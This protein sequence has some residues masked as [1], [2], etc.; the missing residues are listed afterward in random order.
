MP[1]KLGIRSSLYEKSVLYLLEM[2]NVD[3]LHTIYPLSRDPLWSFYWPSSPLLVHVI[4]ECPLRLIKSIIPD[5]SLR[6]CNV[7]CDI[8]KVRCTFRVLH[9]LF[10]YPKGQMYVAPKI[11]YSVF[12]LTI[13]IYGLQCPWSCETARP[14]TRE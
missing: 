9:E 8:Q 4:I 11:Y 3:I 14:W 7:H 13:T 6:I 12:S 1:K 2:T 5:V 10:V